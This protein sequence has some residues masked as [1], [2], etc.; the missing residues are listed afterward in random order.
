MYAQGKNK[1]DNQNKWISSVHDVR[2]NQVGIFLPSANNLDSPAEN[3]GFQI[4][5]ADTSVERFEDAPCF[6]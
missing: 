1:T 4:T 2:S 5:F 6:N 3:M